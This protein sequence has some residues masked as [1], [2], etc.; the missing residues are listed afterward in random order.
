MKRKCKPS[1]QAVITDCWWLALD[2][3][4]VAGHT[5]CSKHVGHYKQQYCAVSCSNSV[6]CPI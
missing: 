2:D 6:P 5:V 4:C 3:L 1:K